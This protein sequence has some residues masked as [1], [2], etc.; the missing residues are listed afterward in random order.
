MM[1]G[2]APSDESDPVLV[3]PVPW[4]AAAGL[5]LALLLAL[6]ANGR[7]I[8][9]G[10][11]RATER[12]A[13]SL[14]TEG[15][16]DLD[17][18]PEVE[19]P[20]SRTVGE[21]RV[22]VYPALSAVL[23]AP[24]FAACRAA[25]A[26]DETGS[27]LAGKLAASILSALAAGALFLAVSR[28]RELWTTTTAVA[29]ALG[30]SVVSTSQA[31]WQ[32]PAAVLFLCLTL[33]F[34]AWAEDDPAW[35]GRAGL[36]L[37]AMVAARHADVA[38]ALGVGAALALR[39]P[40]RLPALLLWALP[41]ALFVAAYDTAYFGAP[42][43][44]GFSGSLSRFAPGWG[45][46]GLLVSPAKGLVVFTPAA[47]VAGVGLVRALRRGGGFLPA[48]AAAGAVAHWLLVG[49]WAEWHGG[50]SWGPRLTTDALPLLFL[51][52]P[53]GLDVLP[54]LGRALIALSIAVQALGAFAY[55]YGW[56]RLHQ[57]GLASRARPAGLWSLAD[58]PL[59]FHLRRGVAIL[60]LPA[61]R[62]GRAIVR[63]HPVVP[64]GPE[65]SRVTFRADGLHVEGAAVFGDVHLQRAARLEDGKL[66]LAHRW[67]ALFLRVR[68]G[69]RGQRFEL[70]L[71]G[72]GRGPLYVGERT[73]WS[74]ATRHATYPVAGRFRLR[75]RYFYPESG[76]ADVTV[77]VGRGGGE[78]SL[79]A[80]EMVARGR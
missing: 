38:L 75:H 71:E 29:F 6:M 19:P 36:P 52:L 74:G 28:R 41:P 9:A 39:F 67:D 11:T 24:V 45:H 69:M 21:H 43:A 16:L 55:D 14:V 20:F 35:V 79:E 22:S 3:V 58:G 64:F 66:V 48:A 5:C 53:E 26:L 50:E 68:D 54:R 65:G 42:W 47:V 56:E 76:G 61:V 30:T 78:V 37:C 4:R 18:Y 12:L 70:V 57:R 63:E 80:V 13:A 8:G 51:F 27:A 32:H 40:R 49:F 59:P 10:D 15:D 73:F 60:A 2:R 7:P 77:T 25:F 1:G 33:L 31:L 46:L 17:E 72:T 34:L 62:D 44:H 23:A